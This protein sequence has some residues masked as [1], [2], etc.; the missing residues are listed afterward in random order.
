MAVKGHSLTIRIDAELAGAVAEVQER[1]GTPVSEQVRR[2]LRMWL[3]TQDV[4]VKAAHRRAAT[5]R[6]A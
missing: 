3:E 2:A 6:K 4:N 1:Y 5:R